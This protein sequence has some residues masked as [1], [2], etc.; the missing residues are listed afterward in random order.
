MRP[1]GVDVC[2]A[3]ILD[4]EDIVPQNVAA[5]KV[6]AWHGGTGELPRLVVLFRDL[7]EK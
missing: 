1:D 5:V 3:V 2:I 4:S 7:S 6:K